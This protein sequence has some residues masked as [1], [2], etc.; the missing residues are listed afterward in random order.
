M[1]S[2]H[3]KIAAA[4]LGLATQ[5]A[6]QGKRGISYNNATWANYFEPYPQVTWAYNWGWPSNG[7]DA[8]IEF[9]PMLWG[10]PSAADPAW[11]QAALAAKHTLGNNEPDLSSQANIIPSVAAA[12]WHTY[13]Q[14][15]AGQV[16]IGGPAVT[17]AGYGAL[18]YEGLGWLDSFLDDCSGCTIN[19]LPVH[20]YDNASATV[21]ENYLT[22][23]YSRGGNRPLWIT[24]FMLEDSEAAQIAFLEEVMPWMDSQSWIARYAYFGAFEDYLING[25]GTG[26]SNIGQTFASYT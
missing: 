2:T 16:S 17:N 26:L 22:E 12:G 15:L 4:L 11:T 13:V 5:A 18:P 8:S 25:A 1:L 21:F 10:V 24:E 20:W 7:L 14:P 19:F 9:V 3:S 23:A 6:A